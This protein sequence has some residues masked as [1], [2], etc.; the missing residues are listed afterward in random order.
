MT[1]VLRMI[2]LVLLAAAASWQPT[3]ASFEECHEGGTNCPNYCAVACGSSGLKEACCCDF[4]DPEEP[5][6]SCACICDDE[7]GECGNY[8]ECTITTR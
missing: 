7:P 3:F 5:D 2:L 4:G 8:P 6:G 1:R